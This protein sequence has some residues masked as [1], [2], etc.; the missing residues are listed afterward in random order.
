[1]LTLSFHDQG[2]RGVDLESEFTRHGP[3]S[4]S[5]ATTE[6]DPGP[7]WS[8]SD[9]GAVSGLFRA[10][11]NLLFLLFLLFCSSA[12]AGG[13]LTKPLYPLVPG[14]VSQIWVSLGCQ[15]GQKGRLRGSTVSGC[16]PAYR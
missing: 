9:S 4:P 14:V 2:L 12:G 13:R 11:K 15:L 8:H 1:M 7:P 3:C 16:L 10:S 6:G 5:A